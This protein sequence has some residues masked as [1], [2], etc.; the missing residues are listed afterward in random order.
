ME[1][2][3]RLNNDNYLIIKL[4]ENSSSSLHQLNSTTQH[5]HQIPSDHSSPVNSENT[6]NSNNAIDNVMDSGLI[7][8]EEPMDV[9][10]QNGEDVS[11]EKTK[12]IFFRKLVFFWKKFVEK[13]LKF[14][15]KF[16]EVFLGISKEKFFWEFFKNF[17]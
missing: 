3:R 5:H 8:K 6:H 12:L 16:L 10:S 1:G 15:L 2:E 11:G 13:F 14:F 17:F 9:S 4:E 7:K